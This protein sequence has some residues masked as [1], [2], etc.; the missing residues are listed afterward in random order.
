[1]IKTL[2]AKYEVPSK[3]ME[4][5]L[6]DVRKL[7]KEAVTRQISELIVKE[8]AFSEAPGL[9]YDTVIFRGKVHVI[10]DDDFKK[11]KELAVR[12]S[13]DIIKRT[14]SGAEPPNK[15][16]DTFAAIKELIELISNY[17]EMKVL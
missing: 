9:D 12:V 16:A 1:M 14:L 13:N 10:P 5:A 2:V 17:T 15:F 8:V 7:A 6:F 3:V 4:S 11:I